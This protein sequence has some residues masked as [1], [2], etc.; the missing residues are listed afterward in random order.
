MYLILTG[1]DYIR[2][3]VEYVRV[4]W[5]TSNLAVVSVIV[6]WRRLQFNDNVTKAILWD[7]LRLAIPE[8]RGIYER[9]FYLRTYS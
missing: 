4:A 3:F 2:L 7:V 1:A 8:S 5:P 9:Y 6:F